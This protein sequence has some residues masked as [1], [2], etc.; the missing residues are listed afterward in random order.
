[1]SVLG[2]C[3]DSKKV[4][5]CDTW[6]SL[7][8][9]GEHQI[10]CRCYRSR[11]DAERRAARLTYSDDDCVDYYARVIELD[12]C[13][14]PDDV[15]EL[16]AENARLRASNEVI[17]EDHAALCAENARLRRD[18]ESVGMAAYLYGR[19]D[20]KARNKRLTKLVMQMYEAFQRVI[21]DARRLDFEMDMRELG[22]EVP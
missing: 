21:P 3:G 17:A 9:I 10:D 16:K 6:D 12:A 11:G 14:K 15:P 4:Y 2:D 18:L 1:M 5:V 19:E 13:W 22:I 7:C 20:L 8:D